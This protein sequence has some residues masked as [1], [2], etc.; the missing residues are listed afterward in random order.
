MIDLNAIAKE[1]REIAIARD[2]DVTVLGCLKHCAG[3]VIEAT[4]AQENFY[5]QLN[6]EAEKNYKSELADIV[7][8]ILTLCA[9]E[10]FD[11]E[12][13]LEDCL[14]K[15]KARLQVVGK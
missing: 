14:K 2:Q 9:E 15:N 4:S 3:E 7:M 1:S 10:D 8:C 5:F 12:K 6:N 11:I 13:M